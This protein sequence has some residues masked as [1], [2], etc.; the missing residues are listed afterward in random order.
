MLKA[1][2]SFVG[3]GHFAGDALK[4]RQEYYAL[5][6]RRIAATMASGISSW[7]CY[8]SFEYLPSLICY[9]GSSVTRDGLGDLSCEAL[10]LHGLHMSFSTVAF[11]SAV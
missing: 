2:T 3:D 4:V 7:A 5:P 6:H 10:I 8:S 11:S 9:G 1:P